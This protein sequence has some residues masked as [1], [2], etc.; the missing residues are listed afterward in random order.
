MS[1]HIDYK[2][3]GR[4]YIALQGGLG[5]QLFQLCAGLFVSISTNKK[6]LFLENFN[7]RKGIKRRSLVV[8]ELLLNNERSKYLSLISS[9]L[10]MFGAMFQKDYAV[11]VDTDINLSSIRPNF[12]IL[13][14]WFQSY[15]LVSRVNGSLIERLNKSDSFL[16]LVQIEQTNAIG[17]H[18]RF[19]DYENSYKT[20]NFHGMTA[21]SYFDEAINYLLNTLNQVDKIIFVTDD[22]D[23][24]KIFV[25]KLR[26]CQTLIPIEVIS[27]TP[28]HDL[29]TLSSCSGIVLSN[30]SF[31]WWAGYLGS[32]LRESHVV[33]PRPWLAVESDYDLTL[34]APNWKFIY[35][36]ISQR[37]DK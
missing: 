33:A 11:S 20:R 8:N 14:G 19:G 23:R 3:N 37:L 4:V 22:K 31:S 30:S 21:S 24:A 5:N 18:L 32:S 1:A 36:E 12:V 27:S 7:F 35:R 34:R 26:S 9:P 10:I 13:N 2:L 15:V 29:A 6:V 28:I 17:I 25:G 16:P